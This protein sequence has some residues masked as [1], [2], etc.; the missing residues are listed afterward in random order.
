V[1]E[2]A[3]DPRSAL[4]QQRSA[5][6]LRRV[7]TD[8]RQLRQL[9]YW[10]ARIVVKS[11]TGRRDARAFR[12]IPYRTLRRDWGLVSLVAARNRRPARR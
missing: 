6:A 11:L 4:T 8:R 10:I 3:L 5:I 12:E 7:V 9:D 2:R 1:V